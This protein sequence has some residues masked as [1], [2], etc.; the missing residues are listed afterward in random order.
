MI[1]SYKFILLLTALTFHYDSIGQCL[2]TFNFGNDT[3]ICIGE[4]IPLSPG[5]Y[6]TYLWQDNSTNPIFTISNPGV[7]FCATE[8][9]TGNNLIANGDFELGNT[10]FTTDYTYYP[11][12]DV[13]GPQA[14]YGIINNAFTWFNPFN[15]CTDHTSGNGLMMV[16]DGSSTNGGN[17]AIWCQS[18]A[19]QNGQKYR[20]TYWVQSV[21]NSPILANIQVRF[22][23][24][25]QSTNLAPNGAC[26]WEERTL[27][28]VSNTTGN[29]SICLYD[30]E[31]A[32]NGNDFAIDDISLELVC[33][34]SD[35]IIVSVG[36]SDTTINSVQICNGDSVFLANDWRSNEG[37]YFEVLSAGDCSDVVEYQLSFF[38]TDTVVINDTI[39][40]ND[41]IFLQNNWQY[42]AGVYYESVS[43]IPCDY[44][45][46]TILALTPLD[47]VKNQVIICQGDSVMINGNFETDE[48]FY[49]NEQGTSSCNQVIET[50]LILQDLPNA[51]AGNN[52]QVELGEEITLFAQDI[53]S[54]SIYWEVNS[55]FV[56]STESI[57]IQINEILTLV[58]LNVSDSLCSNIDTII[59]YGIPNSFEIRVPD[60]FSPNNDGVNDE[61]GVVN[62]QDYNSIHMKI[63]NRWGELIFSEKGDNPSWNGM[64]KNDRSSMDVFVFV[65]EGY[66]IGRVKPMIKTGTLQLIH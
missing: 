11:I 7:Y 12:A 55:G 46:Q 41:S 40:Q 56:D 48:G 64:V 5:Q 16:I 33:E 51:N 63:Y 31:L 50:Q 34:Y 59:V 53:Q 66:L 60:A 28:W 42:T 44:I 10:S 24:V 47:T 2:D 61:F 19:V 43:G 13:F 1:K 3:S 26:L 62:Y 18:V 22:N 57:S 54:S 65:I 32:G 36:E 15:A 25:T 29:I 45:Q 4:S 38:S 52:I 58:Y 49:F 8:E 9:A 30:L 6:E 20:F 21:T 37:S 14:S 23:G 35:T 27:D 17:D 39:C